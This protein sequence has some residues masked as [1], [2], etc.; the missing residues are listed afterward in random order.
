MPTVA[1]T[2][3]TPCTRAYANTYRRWVLLSLALVVVSVS[4]GLVY[5]WPALRG[6]LLEVAA[7]TTDGENESHDDSRAP[8]PGGLTEKRLA[9]VYTLGSWSTQGGRFFLGLARDRFGTRAT[10]AFSLVACAAGSIGVGVVFRWLQQQRQQQQQGSGAVWLLAASLFAIGLGS[11]GQLCLQPVAGLFPRHTGVVLSTL[12]GAF[13]I[14]GLG[15]LVLTRG[16]EGLGYRSFGIFAGCLLGLAV[17]SVLLLPAT[18]TFVV[19]LQRT[20]SDKDFAEAEGDADVGGLQ[21]EVE[22]EGENWLDG[23]NETEHTNKDSGKVKGKRGHVD[24]EK[25]KSDC[26]RDNKVGSRLE[27][28][29]EDAPGNG[30]EQ[31]EDDGGKVEVVSTKTNEPGTDPESGFA[32]EGHPAAADVDD[33]SDDGDS[34]RHGPETT[35]ALQQMAT[36]E[37]V[38]L[39][40]WFSVTIVPMQYYIGV[41]GLRLEAM[42]DDT[43]FYTDLFA[44]CFAGA[45]ATAPLAGWIADRFGLGIAQALATLL[46]ASSVAVLAMGGAEGAAPGCC[47]LG[48]A[49]SV[50][51]LSAYGIGR[52]GVFGLYFTNCGKRFGYANYGTLAGLGLLL[53]AIASLLQYPLIARTA[54]GNHVAVMVGL[55]G[56]LLLQAPYF[57]WLHGRE[58]TE[59]RQEH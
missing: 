50:A 7:A 53:S 2:A 11:G 26:D 6:K 38:L 36:A 34:S 56:A 3:R 37:Y 10:T 24:R 8:A 31:L 58:K 48:G 41:I 28:D 44:Y 47:P 13:Q 33:E 42:G 40:A 29:G 18:G 21:G 43:G 51:G 27:D 35:T 55:V 54:A 49:V 4:S 52:M 32:S 45:A 20:N 30:L 23:K 9:A 57:V 19:P 17:V 1:S 12:S 16:G 15:F 39:C 5:G 59:I 46:V 22:G 25:A 14:S